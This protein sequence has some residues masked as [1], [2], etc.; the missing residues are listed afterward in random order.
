M[1]L[2]RAVVKV[3]SAELAGA[4]I[5]VREKL[6]GASRIIS[7]QTG[8]QELTTATSVAAFIHFSPFP[9]V[10]DMVLRQLA[11]LGSEGFS[12]V[13]ISMAPSLPEPVLQRLR[14]L[15]ALIVHRRNMGLDFGGWHDVAPLLRRRAPAMQELLLAN[16]SLCGPFR[17]LSPLFTTL[18][19]QGEG[20]FGLTESLA[21]RPHLQSFF[22]LARGQRATGD[23]LS[24]LETF[25]VTASKRRT[26]RNGEI[27]L[28]GW[29]KRR[30]HFVG[31]LCGYEAV[32]HAAMLSVPARRRLRTLYPFLFAH[33]PEGA[34]AESVEM[35]EAM[36]QRPTNPTHLFWRELVE[37]FGFPFVKTELL[38]R[39]P[40]GIA[41]IVDWEDL[42]PANDSDLRPLV[43]AHLKSMSAG[44]SRVPSQ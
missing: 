1:S 23:V 5:D 26:I 38:L 19:T 4:A 42:I 7:L 43:Q 41:D 3:V 18:R 9:D 2:T 30:G 39:N 8:D 27:R 24:F 32:E 31:V 33:V 37:E 25:R 35:T 15:S 22:L 34:A 11:S 40:L 36:F 44:S 13:F 14:P 28:S 12:V 16:D 21:P 29:M 10:S 6:R 17:P 20:L